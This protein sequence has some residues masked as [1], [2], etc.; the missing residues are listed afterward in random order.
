MEP[1]ELRWFPFTKGT[2]FP[3]VW[4]NIVMQAMIWQ[5][6]W[7]RSTSRIVGPAWIWTIPMV[8]TWR[9]LL[10][11]K[12][13]WTLQSMMLL[14]ARAHKEL[15]VNKCL[16]QPMLSLIEEVYIDETMISEC[17]NVYFS[18]DRISEQPIQG[19]VH[20]IE[21]RCTLMKPW[22]VSIGT[23]TFV[24]QSSQFKGLFSTLKHASRRSMWTS[25]T[26][27]KPLS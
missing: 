19:I 14:L 4:W 23:C 9:S 6:S 12:R 20:L 26:W 11:L 18:S 13:S 3:V 21:K 1:G 27:V 22:S 10:S 17:R 8:C 25:A 15:Q 7:L 5:P 16:P 24:F 2:L